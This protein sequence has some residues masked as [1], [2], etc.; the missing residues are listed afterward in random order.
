MGNWN[1]RAFVGAAGAA[2]GLA[3]HAVAAAAAPA[4]AGT[5]AKAAPPDDAVAPPRGAG[6]PRIRRG[7]VDGPYGQVHYRRADPPAGTK[8]RHAPLVMFHQNPRSSYEYE[9]LM[10]LMATDRTCLALDTPGYGDSDLPPAPPGIAGYAGALIAALEQ[11][12]FGKGR[13]GAFDAFGFH[14]GTFLAS[15]VAVQRPEM[16]KRLALGGVPFTVG[17]E[18]ARY[19]DTLVTNRRKHPMSGSHLVDAWHSAVLNR[20]ER[21]SQERG[22]QMVL[23]S[24]RAGDRSWWAYQ[25]VFSYD[26]EA[27]LPKVKQPVLLM[28]V[29]DSLLLNT[30]ASKPLYP[31]SQLLEMPDVTGIYVLDGEAPAFAAALR[32]FL[33]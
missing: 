23:V 2:A 10:A 3:S 21:M 13:D 26:A 4:T 17:A 7:F 30:R 28:A 1:R 9:P 6:M 8:S 14:T 32:S 12:G 27:Q 25:G 33:A 18:R 19:Y 5:T 29:N 15:E 20:P 11:L 31:H 16:V 24:L 22:E